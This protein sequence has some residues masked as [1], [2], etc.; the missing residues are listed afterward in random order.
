[1]KWEK[2]KKK[3][4]LCARDSWCG[5]VWWAVHQFLSL[6]GE[7]EHET[8]TSGPLPVCECLMMQERRQ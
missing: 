8:G 6:E 7:K 1:M 2:K 4:I 3:S 5:G